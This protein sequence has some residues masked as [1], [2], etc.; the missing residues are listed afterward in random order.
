MYLS[1]M[2]VGSA[3]SST[4]QLCFLQAIRGRPKEGHDPLK[5]VPDN[6]IAKIFAARDCSDNPPV[7][8]ISTPP[9]ARA[10]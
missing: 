8:H 4:I 2:A 3:H 9:G 1:G 6:R 5:G 7:D 10:V